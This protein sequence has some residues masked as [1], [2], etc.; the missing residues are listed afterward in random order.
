VLESWQV[1]CILPVLMAFIGGT[2][3]STIGSVMH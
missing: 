3:G 1:E 2:T